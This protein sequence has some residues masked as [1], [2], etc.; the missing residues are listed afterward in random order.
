MSQFRRRMMMR[1]GGLTFTNP[2]ITDGLIAMWDGEWNVGLGK[3]NANSKIWVDITGNGHDMTL[4]R[5]NW[6]NNSFV[7]SMTPH[8]YATIPAAFDYLTCEIVLKIDS[9]YN[10]SSYE[11]DV[12]NG[13][14]SLGVYVQYCDADTVIYYNDRSGTPAKNYRYRIKTGEAEGIYRK[15][16]STQYV[17]DSL[18]SGN[19]TIIKARYNSQYKDLVYVGSGIIPSGVGINK[20]TDR[21]FAGNIYALRLYDRALTDEELDYNYLIDESRFFTSI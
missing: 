3:H 8:V 12:F 5:A 10:T 19:K 1:R 13:M 15:I 16:F 7:A 9:V 4:S 14:K 20:R 2:Y 6:S 17:A 18:S 11:A 21:R